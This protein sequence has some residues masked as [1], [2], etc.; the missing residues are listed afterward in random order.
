MADVKIKKPDGSWVS[1][2]GP[3]GDQGDAG[4]QGPAGAAG[5]QGPAGPAGRS[6]SVFTDA[7]EPGSAQEGDIWFQP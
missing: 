4:S 6:V 5:A 1:I 7:S 3:K 2:K